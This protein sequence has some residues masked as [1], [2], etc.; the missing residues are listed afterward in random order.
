[1]ST[2][3]FILGF[4]RFVNRYGIPLVVYSDNAKSFHQAGG[5]IEQLLSSSEFEERFKVASIKHRSIPIYAAWY[6]AAWERLIRVVKQCLYKTLGRTTPRFSEF[7]TLLSDV[8]KVVN[9]RPLTY[10]SEENELNILT[11][12]HFLVGRPLPSLLFGNH[13]QLPE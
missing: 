10:R 8:Q 2:A 5:I 3:E 11:P 9:N 7:I 6:G 1:M 4:V 12:N 13:E